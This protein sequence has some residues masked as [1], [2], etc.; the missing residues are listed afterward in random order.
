[1][2]HRYRVAELILNYHSVA[3]R[4]RR[5]DNIGVKGEQIDHLVHSVDA[6]GSL[7]GLCNSLKMFFAGTIVGRSYRVQKE[8]TFFNRSQQTRKGSCYQEW[9]R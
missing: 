6:N 1:M 5:T 7:Y 3:V 9:I 4:A 8:H 2:N